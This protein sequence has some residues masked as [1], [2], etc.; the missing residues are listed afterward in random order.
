MTVQII[1]IIGRSEQG[2][3]LPFICRGDDGNTYFVKGIGAGRRSQVCEWIAGN[4]GLELGLPL[5][6]L[7]IVDV[8]E[9]LVEN[10]P[11]YRD[12]GVGPAFGSQKQQIMELNYAGIIHVPRELQRAVLAFDWWVHNEDRQ[13]TET[14][15]N[16]NLFWEPEHEKLV[17][18]DHNQA[19][20]SDFSIE[21]FK[22]FHVFSDQVNNLFGNA[23]Y[24]D[25]FSG[26][27]KL[28]LKSW[29]RICDNIPKEWYY[30][31]PERTVLADFDLS[32][33][34]RILERCN[35]ETFWNDHE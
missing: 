26:K 16:P 8:P 2:I 29:K 4:L 24:R 22:E 35:E 18:I 14:G 30:F 28:A 19:F 10:N 9:A 32:D 11:K 3:T 34:L 6:P 20:D 15:G 25:E 31:D 12:L 23:L 33:I 7:E 17:V 13:L 1:E 27:F 5:A 21:K